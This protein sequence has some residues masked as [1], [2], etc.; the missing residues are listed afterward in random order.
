MANCFVRS[1]IFIGT[2]LL[3]AYSETIRMR[4][5]PSMD[6]EFS[7]KTENWKLSNLKS[8]S[9]SRGAVYMFMWLC[10]AKPVTL[11]SHDRQLSWSQHWHC[12]RSEPWG[13]SDKCISIDHVLQGSVFYSTG[14]IPDGSLQNIHWCQT[15]PACE[16]KVGRWRVISE[17][18]C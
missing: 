17:H 14:H 4:N 2:G 7:S 18:L 15:L 9:C 11:P 3:K 16:E 5:E 8:N 12:K 1:S 6:W 13:W 10:L